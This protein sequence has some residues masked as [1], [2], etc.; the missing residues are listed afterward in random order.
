M[1]HEQHQVFADGEAKINVVRHQLESQ[2]RAPLRIL[3]STSKERDIVLQQA[4][5][6]RD[7]R[8]RSESA[9]QVPRDEVQVLTHQLQDALKSNVYFHNLNERNFAGCHRIIADREPAV[10]GE[11]AMYQVRLDEVTI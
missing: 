8:M 5:R 4:R 2:Q 9:A 10:I 6:S 11:R 7:S 3:E 1:A